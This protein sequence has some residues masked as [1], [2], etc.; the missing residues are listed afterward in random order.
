MLDEFLTTNH[1]A[2]VASARSRVAS[3]TCPKPS[4]VVTCQGIPVFLE[5][6]G[7]ALR[8]AQT[9]NLIDHEQIGL[10][11]RRHGHDLLRQGLTIGQVVHDYGDVCQAITDLAVRQ[12]ATISSA[13]FRTL[14]L[15]LDDA[16]A[17]AVTEYARERARRVALDGVGR[18]GLFAAAL[19]K[20]LDTATLGFA[21]IQSGR[22]AAGGSTALMLGRSLLEM[23]DLIDRSLAEVR[24]EAGNVSCD[25]LLVSQLIEDVEVGAFTQAQARGLHFAAAPVAQ[26]A[27]VRGDRSIVM[28]MLANLLQNAFAF[29]R[30]H[31]SVTLTVRVTADRVLFDV[32]DECG[33]LVDGGRDALPA[34]TSQYDGR[35]LALCLKAAKA[36]HG[37]I[38]VRDL[39]AK[40]CIYTLDLPRYIPR[41][42]SA[43]PSRPS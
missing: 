10:S 35:G 5:Q 39:P 1:A 43:G 3:R 32:E 42:P 4:D 11:A 7:H 24:L 23:R 17:G 15:C 33:G 28:A 19:R 22:V 21:S 26:L 37:E 40:G 6:L 34:P 27:M 13:E 8:L 12:G 14:N 41:E 31:T 18:L 9:T 36:S 20:V 30:K 38:R 25:T 29:T 2:I 16:I